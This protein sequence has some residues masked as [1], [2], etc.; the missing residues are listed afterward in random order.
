MK[1]ILLISLFSISALSFNHLTLP[2][3]KTE[4]ELCTSNCMTRRIQTVMKNEE[5]KYLQTSP[6]WVNE[7]APDY[8]FIGDDMLRIGAEFY[9]L[10]NLL[11]YEI[12]TT[13][14]SSPQ[15][16]LILSFRATCD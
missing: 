14:G 2:E 7:P 11:K 8:A 13:K 12:K 4:P 16:R 3:K 9:D 15:K 5:I 10:R 1:A 6:I